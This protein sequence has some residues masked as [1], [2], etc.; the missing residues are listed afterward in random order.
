MEVIPDQSLDR[1]D[2]GSN[3]NPEGVRREQQFNGRLWPIRRLFWLLSWKEIW[4]LN[5]LLLSELLEAVE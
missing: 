1:I 3:G 4:A 5:L 2:A